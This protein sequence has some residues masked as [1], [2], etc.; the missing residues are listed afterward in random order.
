LPLINPATF[1]E[2]ASLRVL[3][4]FTSGGNFL[5]PEY[6]RDYS[7]TREQARDLWEDI[8]SLTKNSFTAD[9]N[10]IASAH[11]HFLGAI[12]IQAFP[13]TECRDQEV[14]DGQQRLVT[15]SILF[16]VLYEF[17]Q[18]L[19][20]Q[21]DKAVWGESIKNML[22]SYVGGEKIPKLKLARDDDHF[23]ELVLNRLDQVSRI[24]YCSEQRFNKNSV[25][26]RIKDCFEYFHLEI[27]QYLADITSDQRDKRLINLIKSLTELTIVLQ[28]KVIEQGAAYEV[29][30]SLNARGL[31]LQQADLLKN[32][33]LSLARIQNSYE[34]VVQ[35]WKSIVKSIEQQSML[36]L[37][38]FFFFHLISKHKECKQSNLYK[39]VLLYLQTP[40]MTAENYARD[41]A[42]TAEQ[43]QQILDAGAQFESDTARDISSIKDLLTNKYA[44]TLLIAG[45][46]KYQLQS[47][48]MSQVI[49]LTNHFVFRRFLVQGAPIATYTYEISQ[50]ARDLSRGVISDIAALKNRLLS[51]SADADFVDSFTTYEVPTN[52]VG[53]YILEMIENHI[54]QNAGTYVHRQSINQHLEHIMPKRPGNSDWGHVANMPNYAEHVNRVGNFLILE[55]DINSY[56]RNKAFDHK[57]RNS[58]LKDYQHSRL[59]LPNAV[60]SYLENGLWNFDSISRRQNVLANAYAAKVWSLN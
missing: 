38:E 49:K 31:E 30:E 8:L 44:L 41:V 5:I 28:M 16:S 17:T 10:H 18:G 14:M 26:F 47:S 53:F 34:E 56:I 40:G 20:R 37:T 25:L 15:L 32:K 7:W 43:L 39:E 24:N 54:S 13:P 45:A 11:P 1:L 3:N 33:L 9:G 29:F 46:S 35:H 60:E 52:K 23:R 27:S 58:E 19:Q 21:E 22:F 4:L 51:H 2:P 55:A 50:C 36:S 42:K 57:N 48:E 59:S 12:V 6:Q